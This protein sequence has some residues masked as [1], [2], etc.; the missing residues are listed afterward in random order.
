MAGEQ[1]RLR[2]DAPER[3][4][5]ILLG[6]REWRRPE[7]D[8]GAVGFSEGA[9]L[10]H[11]EIAVGTGTGEGEAVAHREGRGQ[12]GPVGFDVGREA[13]E[14][15]V[16]GD[17]GVFVVVVVGREA[18]DDVAVHG[19]EVAVDTLGDAGLEGLVL[20]EIVV[21]PEAFGGG[22]EGPLLPV[23][24]DVVD[25]PVGE[26]AGVAVH[27]P[28]RADAGEAELDAAWVAAEELVRIL[29][30]R[31]GQVIGGVVAGF[32]VRAAADVASVGGHPRGGVDAELEA[33]RVHKIGEGAHVAEFGVGLD[34]LGLGIAQ[35]HPAV[36]DVEVG[37][38]VIGEAF[39]AQGD[40][41]FPDGRVA[42]A[43]G[44]DIPA[45]PTHRWGE[46]ERVADAQGE[47]ARGGAVG[48]A[49]GDGDDE[50]AGRGGGATG[51][52]AGD[53]VDAHARRQV[54][55]GEGERLFTRGGDAETEW[56]SRTHAEEG[57]AG[58]TRR[59]GRGRR[60]D[61]A[62]GDAG[63][64]NGVHERRA[65]SAGRRRRGSCRSQQ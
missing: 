19:A 56:F 31:F 2:E 64:V 32:V 7:D 34:G 55:R 23:V 60:E 65:I 13:P 54:G 36:V 24:F 3:D 61:F 20:R 50:V 5:E 43:L 42:H 12:A 62:A 37:P 58:E 8:L 25:A 47:W 29:A 41:D 38:A 57:G 14:V 30:F 10:Q 28:D 4:L 11:V 17:E 35:A 44:V 63:V 6:R 27:E 33:L 9:D 18:D 46:R 59:G 26:L 16:T 53:R 22:G 51:E 21:G 49:G 15:A 45:V 39:L 48:V 52:P 1:Q 40:G